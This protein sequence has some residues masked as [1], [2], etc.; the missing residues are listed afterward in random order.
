MILANGMTAGTNLS[1]YSSPTDQLLNSAGVDSTQAGSP[2][3]APTAF[4]STAAAS[5]TSSIWGALL[6]VVVLVLVLKYAMQHEKSGM[7]PSFMGIGVYNFLAV[8]LMAELF[9]ILS[10]VIVNKYSG[11][12]PAMTTLINTA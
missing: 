4:T 11:K 10:K 7:S 5:S 12:W 2:S 8:G 1:I 9:I 3:N 6:A